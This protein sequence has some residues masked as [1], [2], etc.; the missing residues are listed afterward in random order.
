MLGD[1]LYLLRKNFCEDYLLF[2]ELFNYVK[3][4]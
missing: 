1:V 3:Y 2:K 4:N